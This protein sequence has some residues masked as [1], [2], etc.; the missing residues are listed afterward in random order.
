MDITIY[1]LSSYHPKETTKDRTL[2][3]E[4]ALKDWICEKKNGKRK[5]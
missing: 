1:H 2:E 3:E 4:N 5:N